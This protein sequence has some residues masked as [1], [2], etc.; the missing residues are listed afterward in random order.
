MI[1]AATATPPARLRS[2]N[3]RQWLPTIG[4]GLMAFLSIAIAAI[5]ARYFTFNPAV[6][7]ETLRSRM[8]SHDPWL[9]LHIGGGVVAL[10]VGSFQF[11]RLLR[12]RYLNLHRWTGRVYLAAVA[13]GGVASFRM[14]LESYGG[15]PTHFGFGMLAVL[16]LFTS[17]MAYVRIRQRNIQSHR[18]WMIRSFALTFAAVMLRIWLPLF[19]GVWKIDF[20]QAFDTISWLCWVPNMLVAEVLVNQSRRRL[21]L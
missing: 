1:P 9:F 10:A 14:A 12:T 6:A 17:A 5:S 19:V 3:R 7:A 2:T 8:V 16:W 18:E 4:W 11:S 15:Q 13:I 21:A 20:V